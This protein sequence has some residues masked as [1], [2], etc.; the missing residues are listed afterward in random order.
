M[1]F[2]RLARGSSVGAVAAVSAG[3]GMICLQ[4]AR[5]VPR[6]AFAP[7]PAALAAELAA[8]PSGLVPTHGLS[9]FVSPEK[10]QHRLTR[11]V[12][13]FATRRPGKLQRIAPRSRDRSRPVMIPSARLS[14]NNLSVG[15][16]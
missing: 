10:M 5:K 12:R 15:A 8:K 1:S 13:G 3:I 7:R 9:G 6:S 14:Q 16:P 11:Q 2:F 4:P